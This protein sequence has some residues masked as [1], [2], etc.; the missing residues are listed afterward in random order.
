MVT[1]CVGI[2]GRRGRF[3]LV[4]GTLWALTGSIASAQ[5]GGGAPAASASVSAGYLHEFGAA[6]PGGGE[7]R[8]SRA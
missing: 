6:V 3:L 2:F 8:V 4:A 7:F 1:G 5:T